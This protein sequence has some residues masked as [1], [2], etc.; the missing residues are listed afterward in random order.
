M[1]LN[2]LELW[3]AGL[4]I[5]GI[6]LVYLLA[7]AL[8]QSIPA[9]GGLLGHTIGILGF[10]L[11][12]AT[13]ILYTLRKQTRNARWG[14]MSSWLK[15][16]IFMGLVGPYMVLLHTSWKFSGLAGMVMLLTVIIVV[17]GFF[18]RY[19]YTAAPRTLD[20][21][22]VGQAELERQIKATEAELVRLAAGD[23]TLSGLLAAPEIQGGPARRVMG[24]ILDDWV[25]NRQWRQG[26]PHLPPEMRA[27]SARL[28]NLLKQRRSLRRQVATLEST[29][30]LLS[31]WHAIHIPIGAALFT[32]AFIHA[33]AA[34]YYATLLR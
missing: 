2:N 12:L 26:L 9:A 1:R 5:L 22:E 11:M 6:S 24:R 27:Q 30:R 15:F 32:T 3:L 31:L 23:A 20:G 18:G 19:I 16:H 10:L 4:A 14:P 25:F 33:G 29:H 28:E 34:L 8:F 17:S 21:V 7:V 13:E